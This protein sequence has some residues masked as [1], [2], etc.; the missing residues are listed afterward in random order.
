[1]LF[2]INCKKLKNV[3]KLIENYVIR[4]IFTLITQMPPPRLTFVE[5]ND[6]Y[7]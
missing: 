1:M 3:I 2:E 6:L 4:K 7:S 5:G